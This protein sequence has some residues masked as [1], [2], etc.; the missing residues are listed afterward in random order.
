[1]LEVTN[2]SSLDYRAAVASAWRPRREADDDT[3]WESRIVLLDVLAT[4]VT[5]ARPRAA[6]EIGVERGYSSAV[7]LAGMRRAGAGELYSIDLPRFR[8]DEREFVGTVIPNELRD[9]WHLTLGPSH[10]K[11]RDVLAAAGSLDLFVHDGDHSYESQLED[12]RRA[13]SSLSTGGIVVVDGV[14]SPS[15]LDFAD[16]VGEQPLLV[17]RWDA[18]DAIGLLRKSKTAAPAIIPA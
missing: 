18:Y 15:L 10:T 14:W 7:I 4:I 12:L 3:A 9:H 2:A 8:E 13:W 5:L 6:I 16:E 11:L 17:E 1:V